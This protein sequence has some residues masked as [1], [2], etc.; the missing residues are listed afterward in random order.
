MTQRILHN[1]AKCLKCEDII[2]SIHRHDFVSCSCGAL[3][4][5]GGKD[6]LKRCGTLEEGS[7]EDLSESTDEPEPPRKKGPS[8][9]YLGLLLA[10]QD[11]E[12]N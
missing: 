5:D 8:V 3:S 2:E 12:N 4:V 11:M 9:G 7:Y 1:R 6:Y 10:L